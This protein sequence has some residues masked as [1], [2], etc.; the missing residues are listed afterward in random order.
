MTELKIPK[1]IL[2]KRLNI[3]PHTVDDADD[4]V[5]FMTD[6]VATRFLN[7]EP[8]Q[9]TA[10]GAKGL[11]D[12]VI[13]SYGTEAPVFALAITERSNGAYLG[14]CGLSVLADEDGVECYF[15]LLPKYWGWG[16]ATE[17]IR[18]LLYFAFVEMGVEKVVS[19]I[20]R[21]NKGGVEVAEGSGM[22]HDGPAKIKHMPTGE[23]YVM[24]SEQYAEMYGR[25]GR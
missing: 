19:N 12:Y 24:T 23:R 3:R 11:L 7:F 13:A 4:F 22:S 10:N 6:D 18:A 17:A 20:P 8:E 15:W 5:E 1:R 16:Y 14:S 21:E 9:R 25:D 2:T